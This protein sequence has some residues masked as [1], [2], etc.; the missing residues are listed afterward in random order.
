M[1]NET[2]AERIQRRWDEG[3]PERAARRERLATKPVRRT[4][5]RAWSLIVLVLLAAVLL[6]VVALAVWF[7]IA[8]ASIIVKAIGA[9]LIVVIVSL[10]WRQIRG[11]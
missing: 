9:I 6:G 1:T 7:L 10:A 5:A 8:S 11:N 4:L 2:S 3:A